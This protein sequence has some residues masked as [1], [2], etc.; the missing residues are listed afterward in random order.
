MKYYCIFLFIGSILLNQSC[1]SDYT[2]KTRDD[3]GWNSEIIYHVFQRS[4][5]DSN[6]DRNG[7]L[8]GL[9]QKLGYLKE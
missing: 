6:G 3:V 8:N 4:F 1:L 5:Y 7:D 2:Q 9:T